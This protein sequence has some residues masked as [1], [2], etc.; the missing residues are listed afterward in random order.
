MMW[1]NTLHL[2]VSLVYFTSFDEFFFFTVFQYLREGMCYLR[3]P[4]NFP[5][6]NL[7]RFFVK[8]S[9]NLSFQLR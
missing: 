8:L 1:L 2:A 9:N 6:K 3:V 4:T 7:I 5:R